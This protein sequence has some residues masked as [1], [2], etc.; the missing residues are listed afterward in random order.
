MKTLIIIDDERFFNDIT[1]VNYPKDIGRVIHLR[2]FSDVL[3]LLNN[4]THNVN[5]KNVLWSFDH[6]LMCYETHKEQCIV[7]GDLVTR[8]TCREYDG[9]DCAKLIRHR[10][11]NIQY[12]VHSKNPTGSQEIHSVLQSHCV[13]F[14]DVVEEY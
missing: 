7:F 12:F 11:G 3:E 5:F 8:Q 9:V 13:E 4:N 1:W 6:D 10:L 2:T 14:F